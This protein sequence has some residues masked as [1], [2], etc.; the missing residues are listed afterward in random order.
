MVRFKQSEKKSKA[1]QKLIEKRTNEILSVAMKV[2]AKYGFQG[3]DM[4]KVAAMAGV[5]KGTVYRYFKSK[6]NLFFSVLEWGMDTLHKKVVEA[7]GNI[8]GSVKKLKVALS[9]HLNFFEENRDFYRVLIL[10]EVRHRPDE[11]ERMK[12]KHLLCVGFLESILQEG[13]REGVFKKISTNSGAYALW[14]IS[15][16][17]IFKWLISDKKYPIKREL[18]VIEEIYFSGI[19]RKCR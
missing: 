2:F 19:L 12:K 13:V 11:K 6:E 14:G 16:T 4:E 17:C 5:G 9:T 15:N 1:K 8:K 18:S 7:V 3:A 10:E